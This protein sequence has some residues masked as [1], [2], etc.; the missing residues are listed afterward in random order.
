MTIMVDTTRFYI[1]G[2]WVQ[3]QGSRL[4]DVINPAT[5]TAVAQVA[6]GTSADVDRAVAAARKAFDS[7]SRTTPAERIDLLSAILA[8]YQRRIEEFGDA[9]RQE[10]GAPQGFAC[11]VQAGIGVAHLAQ[12]I[13]TARSF[14][15][16]E[17]RGFQ[18]ILREPVGV[19]GLITPWNW[20]IN[21]ITCKVGPA[22]AAGC[23][24]VLKPSEMAPL[25]AALF[26]EVM[27]EAGVPAGV[28]NL[29]HGDGPEVGQAI[30]AHPDIDMVSFTG[31]TRAGVAVAKMAADTVKRV[32]QELGGKS[33]N[34]ILADADLAKAVSRGVERCFGNSGQSCNAPTR[35]LVPEALYEQVAELAKQAAAKAVVGDPLDTATT[36]GPVS[37]GNQFRKIQSLIETGIAEGAELL[38]G[39]PGRPE[40]LE[41][42]YFVR[43]TIFGRVTPEMT[44]AR[45]E[46]FGPVLSIMTY[47]DEEEAIR[48]ANDT[49]YGLA[50][51]VQSGDPAHGAAVARRLRAGTIY[52][53]D[54]P[55]SPAVPFGG[56]GQSGNGREYAEFGL[57]E[58]L[59]IKGVVGG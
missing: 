42:G 53:N 3:P 14:P 19:V 35:M 39:G 1:D 12:T 29:V 41:R 21:Q 15:F 8:A 40:G 56:Y 18:R 16:E 23:T 46:I 17:D 25:S 24:M 13:E 20:P 27:H 11:Q 31:S 6:L 38:A 9:I 26:T 44:I 51:Y 37:N 57:A 32:T 28:F 58:F 5:E 36:H 54:P 49:V 50:G 4:V 47:R 52:V 33:P 10:M 7:F 55:W 34:I 48:I 30:S 59:E 2:Q 45:E 43:P 22:I